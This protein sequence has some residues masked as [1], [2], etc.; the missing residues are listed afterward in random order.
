MILS[1]I[2]PTYNDSDRLELCLNALIKQDIDH[3][4]FEVIV[5][6]NDPY[7]DLKI[8]KYFFDNLNLQIVKE[9]SP[10]SYAARNKG[11]EL[12]KAEIIAFTDSDCIPDND[13]LT[14]GI[15]YF[16]RDT[17]KKIGIVAGNVPLFFKDP[18]KLTYAEIY[19]KYTGFDFESYVKEGSCGA[20]N[21]FSYKSVLKDFGGFNPKLKS[22]GDTDLSKRISRKYE[23]KFAPDVIVRHPARYYVKDI[24]Y[25]YRRLIGGT[26]Q[27]RFNSQPLEFFIYIIQ[28]SLRRLRFSLKKFFTV[29]LIESWAIFVVCMAI[30]FGVW[31]EYFYLIR[32][33]ETKR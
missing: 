12:A 22:N 19:E 6:D 32:G 33:G 25:K 4:R 3:S 24:V 11:I 31:K 16:Q 29:P 15:K 23:I 27:R 10:G 14:N 28:F 9:F 13:W 21:W 1:L 7:M 8:S 17:L 2:I 18:K 26:F 5:V 20:G 30:N